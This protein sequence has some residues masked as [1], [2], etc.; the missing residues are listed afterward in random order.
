MC[1]SMIH[2]P[3]CVF[4]K[5][6]EGTETDITEGVQAMYDLLINSA[7]WGS[8][9][10]TMEDALPIAHLAKVCSFEKWEEAEKYVKWAESNFREE[11][12]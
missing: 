11:R 4:V 5:N 2:M 7:D 12:G 8:G 9:F 3:K 6:E 10:L 1:G